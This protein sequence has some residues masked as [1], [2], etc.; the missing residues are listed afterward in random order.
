MANNGENVLVELTTTVRQADETT[1]FTFKEM[2]TIVTVNGSTYIRYTEKERHEDPNVH[3]T[4][5]IEP[6]GMVSI[7]RNGANRTKL[8]F[9]ADKFIQNSIQT[10]YGLVA[11]TTHTKKLTIVQKENPTSGNVRL[12]YNLYAGEEVVGNYSMKLKYTV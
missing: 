5:K 12:D 9:L 6:S 4:I 11:L 8:R 7:V 2:G 1:K 3:V 10:P